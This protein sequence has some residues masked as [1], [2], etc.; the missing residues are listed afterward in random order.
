MVLQGGEGR[1]N[2]K[3]SIHGHL[4]ENCMPWQVCDIISLQR[5]VINTEAGM[6]GGEH[7]RRRSADL[8]VRCCALHN[9]HP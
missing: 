6:W 7:M 9:W 5:L 3:E 2:M 4:K 8:Q 1:K